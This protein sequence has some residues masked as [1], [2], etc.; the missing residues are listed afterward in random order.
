MQRSTAAAPARAQEHKHL[1]ALDIFERISKRIIRFAPRFGLNPYNL[2]LAETVQRPQWAYRPGQT[3]PYYDIH[4][5]P[6]LEVTVE[7]TKLCERLID[8]YHRSLGLYER[9]ITEGLW[10]WVVNSHQTNLTAALERRDA[11]ELARLL[12]GMFREKFMWGI[13]LGVLYAEGHNR[14]SEKLWSLKYLN[15]LVSLAEY[16]G[17]VRT[18]CPEQGVIAYALS[19]GAEKLISRVEEVLGISMDVPRVGAPHGI[20]VGRTLVTCDS[21]EHLYVAARAHRLMGL[22]L[23]E[24]TKDV[25]EIGAG[26]GGTA[27]WMVRLG[28]R[29]YTIIDLPTTNV[30]QGYYLSKA[31]GE[32]QVS[33]YGEEKRGVAVLPT[34]A[35]KTI[36]EPAFDLI[37]NE[38]SMPEMPASAVDEYL[39]WIEQTGRLFYSY[40]Q[41]A[42][43]PWGDTPQVLVPEAA[44]RH[45]FRL[46]ER[47]PSWIRRG[48]VESVYSLPRPTLKD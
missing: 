14:L 33:L 18:E 32:G 38:N 27:Y 47:S 6:P 1:L 31:L 17:V 19:D 25:A 2:M 12:S 4:F 23:K 29:S 13:S 8:S 11:K 42:F 10:S 7:D 46:L 44:T 43:S 28:V 24:S 39:R 30:L 35:I 16:L 5:E 22:F 37:I 15:A 34:R 36:T 45:G 20:R 3:I 40:N 21:P 41:E 48:Y 26:Y 9:E